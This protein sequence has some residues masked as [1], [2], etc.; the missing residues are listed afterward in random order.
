MSQKTTSLINV[1]STVVFQTE[2]KTSA[3]KNR[4][5]GKITILLKVVAIVT[6]LIGSA[7]S[8]NTARN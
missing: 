2:G 7:P 6:S 1:S 5:L 4:Y 8:G 3:F